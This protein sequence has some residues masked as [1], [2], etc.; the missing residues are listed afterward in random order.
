MAPRQDF[1]SSAPLWPADSS[2]ALIDIQAAGFGR[3]KAL[4]TQKGLFQ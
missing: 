3:E 1:G 2:L 4:Q